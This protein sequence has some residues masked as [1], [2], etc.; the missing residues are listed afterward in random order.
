MKDLPLG[1]GEPSWSGVTPAPRL[2]PAVDARERARLRE[3]LE[4]YEREISASVDPRRRA[5]LSHEVGRIHEDAFGDQRQAIREYQ[6]AFRADP[7][8]LP[9][10]VAV[11]RLFGQAGKWAMVARVLAAEI[12]ARPGREARA[13][14]LCEQGDLFWLRFKDAEGARRAFQAAVELAPDSPRAVAGLAR[15]AGAAGAAEQ[16]G[17]ALLT[18]SR[19]VDDGRAA[20]SLRVQA[21]EDLLTSRPEQAAA[22]TRAALREGGAPARGWAVWG[23]L[24]A[25]G[26]DGVALARSAAAVRAPGARASLLVAAARQAQGVDPA[27]ALG[28][29]EE[30]AA[31]APDDLAAWDLIAGLASSLAQWGDVARAEERAAAV[32]QRPMDR[33]DRLWRLA[34]TRLTR[35]GEVDAAIDALRALLEIKPGWAP[36]QERLERLLASQGDWQAVADARRAGIEVLTD[37]HEQADAWYRL[38]VLLEEHLGDQGA[39]AEAYR[40]AVGAR[41]DFH[42]AGK[43]LGR[44]LLASGDWVGYAEL[45]EAEA[46]RA[47]SLEVRISLLT[48]V[49]EIAEE[50]LGHPEWALAACD[51]ILAEDPGHRATAARA[52]RLLA[53]LGRWEQ[54]LEI[55]EHEYEGA[56]TLGH[57][58]A[59]LVRS[60]EICARELGDGERALQYVERA[61]ALA[62][63]YAPA[64]ELATVVLQRQ[65]D[66]QGLVTLMQ[67]QLDATPGGAAR[68]R[69]AFRMGELRRDRLGD[70][71]GA[72]EAFEMAHAAAGEDV[73]TLLALAGLYRQQ[74][75]VAAERRLLAAAIARCDEPEA[76]AHLLYRQGEHAR[77]AGDLGAA[78]DAWEQALAAEPD[79]RGAAVALLGALQALGDDAGVLALQRRLARSAT[80]PGEAVVHWAAVGRA[81]LETPS[82]HDD[83]IEAYEAIVALTPED[84]G[85]WLALDRLYAAQERYADLARVYGALADAMPPGALRAEW[86]ARRG[87][88]RLD[89]LED[90]GGALR[91]F[92][93]V[94]ALVPDHAEALARVERE[95]ARSGDVEGLAAVLEQRLATAGSDKERVLVLERAGESLWRAD[96]LEDAARCYNAVV[97]LDPDSIAALRALRTI[98]RDLGE[99]EASALMTEAEGRQALDP[100]NAVKLLLEAGSA[101]EA[102]HRDPAGALAD[103]RAALA[104]DP[105]D[106]EALASVRRV[107]ERTGRWAELAEQLEALAGLRGA[108]RIELWREAAQIYARRLHDMPRGLALMERAAADP[109]APLAALQALADQ[110]VELEDWEGAVTAYAAVVARAEDGDLRRA[111]ALRI[112]AIQEDKRAAPADAVPWLVQAL[113]DT[114]TAQDLLRLARTAQ[115]AG[116]IQQARDALATALPLAEPGTVVGDA[117]RQALA[118]LSPD[119]AL[120]VE[121]LAAVAQPEAPLV[122]ARRLADAAAAVGDVQLLVEVLGRW[123]EGARGAAGKQIR[124]LLVNRAGELGASPAAVLPHVEAL[125][126]ADPDD[127]GLRRLHVETLA[128]VPGGLDRRAA[129][130][131]WLLA[132]DPLSREDLA[133]LREVG[134]L[135]GDLDRV[136]ELDR[137]ITALEVDDVTSFR[138]NV[139]VRPKRPLA[140]QDRRLIWGDAG[141][142]VWADVLS[143]VAQGLPGVFRSPAVAARAAHGALPDLAREVAA[144]VGE[145]V[146][147]V[148]LDD[149]PL[150]QVEHVGH[151][152]HVSRGLV[153]YPPAEQRFLL[154]TGLALAGRQLSWLPRWSA[155]GLDELLQALVAAAAQAPGSPEAQGVLPGMRPQL[156]RIGPDVDRLSQLMQ[157]RSV[158]TA[159]DEILACAHRVGLLVCGGVGPAISALC[160]Q[161]GHPRPSVSTP[162]V[163]GVV[164]WVT[165]DPYYALRRRVGVAQRPAPVAGR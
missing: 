108:Q 53:G 77:T 65:G 9:T 40:A 95:A 165:G 30:A 160:R 99:T 43:A 136:H 92:Q 27:R 32:A 115:T 117:V 90:P 149:L 142:A 37:P 69:L 144:D 4:A 62:P 128:G 39:A 57:Q 147:G 116:L 19:W 127:G 36:A 164:R 141:P 41:P 50:R 73:S 104:R 74:G 10:L 111:V 59:L 60:A 1:D 24:G 46:E 161:A 131:R 44:L 17:D 33:V 63:R 3:T 162:G 68:A 16:A 143:R 139:T 7:T 14:L 155:A 67:R 148:V 85:A 2:G 97:Q 88:L 93:A 5:A 130:I 66:W 94:L 134:A 132:R 82:G 70:T 56:S 31:L 158:A 23:R 120:R 138:S 146:G 110:R 151:T 52:G 119:P 22:L 80:D 154:G 153:E 118:R 20:A 81:G 64:L 28:L 76:R 45:L 159:R 11:R 55:N 87:R 13:R 71:A 98:Y 79:H 35:L 78:V 140:A 121:L 12:K 135:S 133:Q 86:L 152:L 106:D 91:D 156:A 105:D 42:D 34:D 49:A 8:H 25:A 47:A 29:A 163:V 6:R 114:P 38:G 18:L 75:D 83:A 103:Y 129:A 101:R 61:L 124:R 112:A 84:L 48:R 126:Q 113:G 145:A 26:G 54:L 89:C 125:I 157:S 107:C 102:S 123:A 51:Q 72:L 96:R 100:R 58:L 109:E 15:T 137:L 150:G 122:T 21:A